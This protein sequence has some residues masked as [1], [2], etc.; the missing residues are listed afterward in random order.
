MARLDQHQ[1][2][3]NHF[4][5]ISSQREHELKLAIDP[6][7]RLPPLSGTPLPP[8]AADLHLLQ[9]RRIRLGPWEDYPS[10]SNRRGK[11][12]WQLKLP[13][14]GDRQEVEV[15]DDEAG[16]PISLR[17]LLILHLGPR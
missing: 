9:H 15:A 8:A 14:G 17:R 13:L 10:S 12:S 4:S 11:K 3:S 7:F 1:A 5:A 6:D 16:P 2:P